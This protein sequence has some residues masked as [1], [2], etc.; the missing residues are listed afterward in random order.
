MPLI[1]KT[2]Y[3]GIYTGSDKR[4]GLVGKY[5]KADESLEDDIFEFAGDTWEILA[6]AMSDGARHLHARNLAI[7]T[8][9]D[10]IVEQL[11]YPIGWEGYVFKD[12]ANPHVRKIAQ[13]VGMYHHIYAKH[14]K[15]DKLEGAKRLW[16]DLFE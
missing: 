16:N 14:Q 13:S 2:L 10:R 15:E 11:N 12:L 8:N 4:S 5:V 9:D 7:M 6:Q 1:P 3:L